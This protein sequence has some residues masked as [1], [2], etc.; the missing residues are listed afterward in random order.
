MSNT[1]SF[2]TCSLISILLT[3]TRVRKK[4]THEIGVGMMRRRDAA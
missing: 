2:G 4:G 1:E 3:K